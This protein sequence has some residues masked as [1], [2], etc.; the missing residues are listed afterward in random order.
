MRKPFIVPRMRKPFTVHRMMKKLWSYLNE[1]ALF[2]TLKDRV[3][4][5]LLK[6]TVHE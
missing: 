1:A 3:E 6:K 4:E 5:Y 2:K